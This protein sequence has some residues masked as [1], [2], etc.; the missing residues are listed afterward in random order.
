MGSFRQ[1][2]QR[3]KRRPSSLDLDGPELTAT[4]T[5]WYDESASAEHVFGMPA[6]PRTLAT[7]PWSQ[8]VQGVSMQRA[9]RSPVGKPP[10]LSEAEHPDPPQTPGQSGGRRGH[11]V[12]ASGDSRSDQ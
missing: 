4:L 2:G 9:E 6:S 1:S 7:F 8:A 12:T 10:S 5:T 3:N 11:R